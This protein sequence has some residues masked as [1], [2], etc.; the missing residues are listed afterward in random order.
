MVLESLH[1]YFYS[2]PQ[3]TFETDRRL[4]FWRCCVRLKSVTEILNLKYL[5]MELKWELIVVI[6]ISALI[7][8]GKYQPCLRHFHFL[9]LD[10]WLCNLFLSAAPGLK[11]YQCQD[12]MWG[13]WTQW[14]TCGDLS[15]SD[16][17]AESPAASTNTF[18]C[19]TQ[20]GTNNGVK[21]E[22]RS[23][24]AVKSSEKPH[25]VNNGNWSVNATLIFDE[26][27][28]CDSDL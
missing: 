17:I 8:E 4:R 23:L 25:C 14:P 2:K 13:A 10:C 22:Y 12:G 15:G 9:I 1:L 11:C 24:N 27:C 26:G 21:W 3:E 20:N 18:N 5:N 19:F 6:I 7:Q 16:I 28:Y